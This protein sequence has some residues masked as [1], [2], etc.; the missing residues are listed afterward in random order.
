MNYKD[1][2][3]KITDKIISQLQEG[4]IPWRKSWKIGVPLN[5]ITQ[6]PYNGINFL[7]LIT[8]EYPSPYYLTYLQCQQ[9]QGRIKSGEKG[10]LIVYWSVKEI[11]DEEENI[12]EVPIIKYSYVFNL[13][14]TTLYTENTEG[15]IKTCE[16]IIENIKDEIDIRHNLRGCYY[17]SIRDV[18]SIPPIENF[19][20]K[21]E[22]YSS[23]FHEII[24]W[25]G[26]K[27]RLNRLEKDYA[28]EELIAEIGS[29]YLC[30]IAHISNK[31]IENQSAYING[32]LKQ[33]KQE[34]RVLLKAAAEANKAINYILKQKEE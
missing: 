18:I 32:W 21:E 29:A 16:E 27:E 33:I 6:K 26:H 24:H 12:K 3:R 4:I 23:L 19:E 15:L 7:N 30:G 17:D 10:H 8:E 13:S 28:F 20:S 1:I 2:I 31:T 14:Q 9:K 5:Y 22:Y 11:I 34:P 25:T